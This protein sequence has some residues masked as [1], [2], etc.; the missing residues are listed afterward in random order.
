MRLKNFAKNASIC[1]VHTDATVSP[2]PVPLFVSCN[3][4]Y[5]KLIPFSSFLYTEK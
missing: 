3:T 2:L 4:R 1:T 5:V